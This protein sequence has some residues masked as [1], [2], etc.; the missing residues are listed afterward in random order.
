MQTFSPKSETWQPPI[1]LQRSTPR[2]VTLT[3]AGRA[4]SVVAVLLAVGALVL[5]TYMFRTASADV[6]R[7]AAWQAEAVT[8]EGRVIEARK[9]GGG[10]DAKLALTYQYEAG[11]VTR[12]GWARL[13]YSRWR[14]LKAGM[15]VGVAY[16][17]SEPSTSWV[18]GAE[19]KGMPMLAAV[20]APLSLLVVAPLLAWQV[21]RQRRLLEEGR[22]ALAT[23]TAKRK[24]SSQHGSHVSVEYEFETMAGTRRKGRY[25][26]QRKAPE[27]GEKLLVVY[28]PDE[29]KWSAKYP[30]PLVRVMSIE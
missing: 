16:R 25:R 10:D 24:V 21:R 3:V 12:S 14:R 2:E 5:F 26:A 4:V 13:S 6:E 30:L 23:V 27:V 22:P 19:P 8:T 29:E 11:G 7:W 1:E 15:T 20:L 18:V 28:H 9:V 17:T